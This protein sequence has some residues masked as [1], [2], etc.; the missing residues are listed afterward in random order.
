MTPAAK[1]TYLSALLIGL[2]VGLLLGYRDTMDS[3]KLL[4]EMRLEIPPLA[5]QDFSREQYTHADTERGREALLNYASVLE[6]I[7]K[8]KGGKSLKL[9]LGLTYTR[10]ALLEEDAGNPEQS[11]TF[12]TKARN[13]YLA[14]GDRD[15]SE[16]EMKA[17][18]KRFDTMQ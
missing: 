11:D 15:L 18:L 6:G 17:I 7:E 2:G 3:L 9:E 12:M 1:V 8:A 16:T 14:D 13:W 4:G 5:L 10:L